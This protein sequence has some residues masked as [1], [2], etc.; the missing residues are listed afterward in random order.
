MEETN[1]KLAIGDFLGFCDMNG[2]DAI[3]D[4]KVQELEEYIHACQESASQG[5]ELVADAIY[6]RLMEI[7]SKVNPESEL[8][9]YIW[10]D[11]VDELDDS[12]ELFKRNPMYSIRTCKS[13]D[14]QEIADFQSLMPED[15]SITAHVSVKLNGHGIRL[16][17][18]NGAFVNAR[19]RA[20]SSAGRDIT[21]QLKVLMDMYGTESIPDLEDFDWCEIR[22]E[23][24]LP[25][26]NLDEA[27]KY[28]PQIVSAF[29]GVSSMGR[30]SAT[31][32][33]WGLLR[34]VAYKF[35][36]DGVEFTSKSEEYE[37]LEQ[38]GFETPLYWVIED[39]YKEDF[40]STLKDIVSDCE[41]A[42]K[43]DDTGEN[44]YQY[45]TDG[46]VFEIND[47]N[48]FKSF[49][50]DGSK[51]NLGNLAL[52]VGYWKQDMYVGYVQTILWMRGKTKISPVAIIAEEP[53]IITFKD[54]GDHPYTLDKSEIENYDKLGVVTAGGNKV[55]RVPLYEPNN[56]LMLEAF[57][58]LPLHFRY[59]GE[60]GVTPCFPSGAALLSE[61]IAVNL[62]TD[63]SWDYDDG[64]DDV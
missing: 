32:E 54:L 2:I 3:Q 63:G 8:C 34:F 15:E 1:I 4:D 50:D 12:D 11:S 23:W 56:I 61:K 37:F 45:Y 53:D 9:K 16:K 29:T 28:N 19:S 22:G 25:F 10:E 57:V 43:P 18:H 7:L 38:L 52:K 41:S 6:D 5:I 46:L 13:Y 59:G 44:G 60:S 17:F 40:I 42:V 35:V 62:S 58:G 39:I 48:T 31:P 24:V 51:Y 26:E 21:N 27:R 30:D 20:R 64:Y 47:T 55:R 36:A 14:C 49:G 33:E